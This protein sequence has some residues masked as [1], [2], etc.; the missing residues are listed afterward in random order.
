MKVLIIENETYL[1][2]SIASRLGGL[3]Y[4][5]TIA[6]SLEN[7]TTVDADVILLSY[8]ACGDDCEM[9]IKN[10]A[11]RA[12]IIMLVAYI[13]DDS[14]IKPINAGAKDYI[15]K[16]FMIDELIRK[17]NHYINHR[18]LLTKIAFYDSYFNFVEGELNT[19]SLPHYRPPFIIKSNSQ[20]SADIYAMKYAREHK[21]TF[22]IL[23]FADEGWRQMLKLPTDRK[24]CY[25]LTNF[26]YLKKHEAKEF[27]K[28]MSK[29]NVIVSVISDDE[30]SFS[31]IVDITHI[32]N[33]QDLGGEI[34]SIKEYE[35]VMITKFEGRYSDIEL[36]KKLGISRKSLWEKRKKYEITRKK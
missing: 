5:C 1:A 20:R 19:P 13:S 32:S 27:L 31:Q 33:Q 17:I 7:F 4:M 30:I 14:I 34:L 23:S 26:E 22:Q 9:F 12:V 24:K 18:A 3:S 2:Q 29:Y 15:L 35:K 11:Q 6:P 21:S 25:Y 8:S 10:H 36:A 28:N 16:P